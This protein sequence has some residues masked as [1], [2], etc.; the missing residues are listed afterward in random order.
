MRTI[1]VTGLRGSV[2]KPATATQ[3]AARQTHG[4]R[5]I[6]VTGLKGGVGKT[7]TAVNL[8]ALAA[9]AGYRV[10]VWDLDPQGAA[11]QC[12]DL[13]TK[14]KGGVERLF[15]GNRGLTT[16]IRESNVAGIDVVPSDVS[17]RDADVVLHGSRRPGRVIRRLLASAA[18]RYDV[19]FLDLAPGIGPVTGAVVDLADLLLVPVIPSPLGVRAF[20]R[21][22]AFA[23]ERTGVPDVIAPFLSIIDRRKPLHRRI[24]A[25]VRGDRRFLGTTVALSSAVERLADELQPTVVSSP[26]SL[27]S[28]GYRKLWAEVAERAG[29]T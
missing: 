9:E 4:M 18:R 7:A 10:L 14:L 21:F 23:I 2:E 19:A 25:E 28:D 6:A 29:L 5:T 16:V 24:E 15:G 17:L 11:T 26:H 22:A 8:A 3:L 12:F 20:D 27:A 1:G 13:H